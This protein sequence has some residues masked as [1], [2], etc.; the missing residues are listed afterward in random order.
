MDPTLLTGLFTDTKA[1]ISVDG[2]QQTDAKVMIVQPSLLWT[3][4]TSGASSPDLRAQH[5]VVTL[6]SAAGGYRLNIRAEAS[7]TGLVNGSPVL[8]EGEVRLEG[9]GRPSLGA[10]ASGYNDGPLVLRGIP[11][12]ITWTVP[13]SYEALDAIERHRSGNDLM[14]VL[15]VHAL[16]VGAGHGQEYPT[17][18]A[19]TSI[20]VPAGEW[21]KQLEQVNAAAGLFV[22]VHAPPHAGDGR[23]TDAVGY[24]RTAR[25]LQANG[26]FE[27]AVAEARK[28]LD[29][30]EEIDP[31]PNRGQVKGVDPKARDKALRWAN[32]RHATVDLINSSPH[33]DAVAAQITWTY[34]DVTAVLAA[35][36][37]LLGRL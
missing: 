7:H 24:L 32:Y 12:G 5:F 13:I 15:S 29:V 28:V 16:L 33:G 19:Q 37:G 27:Q 10:I 31:V 25:R 18:P 8:F 36:A 17:Q 23:R 22:V 20:T 21:V 6:E 30:L 26:Q 14:L 34:D 9:G 3:W 1:R 4:R 2:L 35:V 11:V